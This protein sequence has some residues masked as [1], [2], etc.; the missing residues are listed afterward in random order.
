MFGCLNKPHGGRDSVIDR[1]VD[2]RFLGTRTNPHQYVQ[3]VSHL[4]FVHA[5]RALR[6]EEF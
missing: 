4:R 3:R 2:P 1:A 5:V 6:F